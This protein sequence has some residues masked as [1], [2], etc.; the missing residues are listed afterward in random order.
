MTQ[1]IQE[2]N[3]IDSDL[4]NNPEALSVK[5][6]PFEDMT[7]KDG[8]VGSSEK[9]WGPLYNEVATR[10]PRRMDRLLKSLKGDYF[11]WE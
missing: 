2:E 5:E 3:L 8:Y 11:V 9:T 10:H 6:K 4:D 7:R 1:S